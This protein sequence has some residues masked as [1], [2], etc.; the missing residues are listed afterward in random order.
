M[1]KGKN[2]LIDD[3]N[4]NAVGDKAGIILWKKIDLA[5]RSASEFMGLRNCRPLR[6]LG[7]ND[8]HQTAQGQHHE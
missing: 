8:G 7:R 6:P 3:G 1:I 5:W 4:Q 2:G